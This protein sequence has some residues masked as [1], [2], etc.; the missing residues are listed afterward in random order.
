MFS[1]EKRFPLLSNRTWSSHNLSRDHKPSVKEEEDRIRQQGGR[2][3]PYIDENNEH[4]G[5]ARVWLKE[6]DIPGLAMTRSFG[7]KV[8]STVGVTSLPEI[9]EW[10]LSVE[11]KFFLLASDGV[12]E[13]MESEECISMIKDYYIAHDITGACEFLIKESTERWQR[14]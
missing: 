5:P 9:I 13:F 11:D 12:W 2:I 3:Q 10:Q 7:D 14:V 4:M 6:Q 8:A 1:P